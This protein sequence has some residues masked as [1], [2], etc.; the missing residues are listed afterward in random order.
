LVKE[1]SSAVLPGMYGNAQRNCQFR[2][3]VLLNC[4]VG[5][6]IHA[7]AETQGERDARHYFVGGSYSRP[8]GCAASVAAREKLGL[9]TKR[10]RWVGARNHLDSVLDGQDIANTR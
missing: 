7:V 2:I 1:I 4:T 3:N 9:R 8:L 5:S 6:T 10:W